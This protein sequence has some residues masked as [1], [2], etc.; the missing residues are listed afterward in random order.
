[1]TIKPLK[2]ENLYEKITNQIMALIKKK[3]FT[4]GDKLPC[5]KILSESFE[6]SRSI[7]RES[8]KALELID[9]IRTEPGVGNFISD[10]ALSSINQF[11]LANMMRDRKNSIDLMEVRCF[12]EKEASFYAAK[13]RSKKE[14]AELTEIIEETREKILNHKY[15]FNLGLQFH[16]KIADMASNSILKKILN[17]ISDELITHR[18]ELLFRHMNTDELMYELKEHIQIF[19]YIKDGNP[20]GAREAMETHLL[21]AL[22]ILKDS[23]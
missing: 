23:E 18:K 19:E 2:R 15:N 12:I 11:E 16:M 10:N 21:R 20:Y 14:L 1:M 8:L 9:V 13:R 5:E 7:V 17:N 3:H 22:K 6:V 4:K